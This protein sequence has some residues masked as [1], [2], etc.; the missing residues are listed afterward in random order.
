VPRPPL[1]LIAGWSAVAL[2]WAFSNPPFAAPDEGMHYLRVQSVEQ[3]QLVGPKADPAT[4]VVANEQ[5]HEWMAQA[6]REVEIPAR[7]APVDAGCYVFDRDTSAACIDDFEAPVDPDPLIAV[8]VVGTYQPLPY[9]LPAVAIKAADSPVPALRLGRLA[10]ALLALSLLALAAAAAWDAR[11]PGLSLLGPALAVTP[12][13][14]FCST[15]LNGSSLEITGGIAFIA[16]LFR[17]LRDAPPTWVWAS[18]GVSGAVFV[19]SRSA[20]PLWVMLGVAV[21]VAVHGPRETWGALRAG[22]RPAIAAAAAIVTAIVA[23]LTWERVYGPEVPTGLTGKRL[24]L[25]TGLDQLPR[26]LEEMVGRFGYLEFGLP[27]PA[28]IFWGIATAAAVAGALRWAPIR[29]KVVLAIC[30]V[31]LAVLPLTQYIVFQRH[32]GFGLQ[33]RHV[34]PI[35]VIVPLLAGELLRRN[36]ER[37][38]ARSVRHLIALSFAGIAL[39]QFT[40]VYWNARRSAVGLDGP[41]VFLGSSEWTPPIGWGVWLALAAAGAACVAAAGLL[42]AKTEAAQ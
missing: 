12:M 9:L 37:L 5:Q 30:V 20:T 27:L 24:A 18:A 31:A 41:F 19:L 32:T 35:L 33:G 3:G 6:A 17:L 34:L 23:N 38:A 14:I 40:A 7:L 42:A 22:G 10:S 15:I 36:H 25:E 29:G 11:A 28:Y 8:T 2:A 39:V 1:L 21:V 16:C 26:W 13:V 4:I